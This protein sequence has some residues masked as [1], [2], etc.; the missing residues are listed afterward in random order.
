[1]I[2]AVLDT[3]T[4]VSGTLAPHGSAHRLLRAGLAGQFTLV[5]SAVIIEEVCRTLCRPRITRKY[6]IGETEV[7]QLRTL[8]EEETAVTPLT[9]PVHGVATHPED[10]LILAT[11]LSAQAGYLVTGDHQ[12][13]KL[14][15]YHGVRILS[16]RAFLDLLTQ[17]LA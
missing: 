2:R 6:R 15:E 12:L 17:D 16:P 4:L 9:I 3:N 5:T 13:Q 1:M 10:D 14:G 11:A 7:H 8:L